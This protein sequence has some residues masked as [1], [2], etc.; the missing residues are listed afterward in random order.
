M[1]LIDYKIVRFSHEGRHVS[2]LVRLYRGAMQDV[3]EP[4][5]G[6]GTQTVNRYVRIALVAQRTY[7]YDVP[8][9]MSRE[10]FIVK[11]R[12]YLNNKLMAFAESNGHTV[13]PPQ[14]DTAGLEV[15]AN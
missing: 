8:R 13:I 9:D 14:Q 10:E 7:E 11:A 3:E 15:F 1:A 5:V 6:G 12:A 2:A 4:M